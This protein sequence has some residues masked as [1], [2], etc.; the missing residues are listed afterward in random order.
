M[1]VL[2]YRMSDRSVESL[3]LRTCDAQ[4]ATNIIGDL[5]AVNHLAGHFSLLSGRTGQSR[6]FVMYLAY[7][8]APN[9]STVT[10]SSSLITQASECVAAHFVALETD[11][12][13]LALGN[14]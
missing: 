14:S 10:A 9:Q 4:C 7:E 11:D 13:R 1:A 12:L 5:P 8:L 3:L 2:G 6:H